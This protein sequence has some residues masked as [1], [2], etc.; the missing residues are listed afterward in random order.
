MNLAKAKAKVVKLF[1]SNL[2]KDTLWM[3]FAKLFNIVMQAG[4]FIIVARVLGA[5]NYGSFVGVTALAS[6]VFPF[7]ALG[8]EHILVQ[9][10]STNKASFSNYWGNCLLLLVAN[11][12]A[13]T[14]ILLLLSPLI[15]A[16][17]ISLLTILIILLADLIF[18]G[19]LDVSYKALTAVNMLNKVAH[20]AIFSTCGKLLAA[21]CLW[22]FFTNPSTNTW[23]C[24]Y[25]I[26]SIVM[27]IFSVM[28]VNKLAGYP[29]PLF[30]KLK[31][32]LKEGFYF[33]ISAS[34]YNVNSSLDKTMLASLSTLTATGIYGSAYRFI[35]V[36]YVPLFALFSATYTRF[37]Q[38]G[39]SG[40]KNS[41][42]FAKRLFPIILL[43][44][45]VSVV[46]Y[47]VFAPLL[48]A[49]LGEEYRSAVAALL[50]LAPLP[51]IASFQFL[52]ADTLT[53][54][55]H[56]KARSFVQV[57]AA[58]INVLLNIWLIPIY[59]W[60]G[61]AWATLI[62]DSLRLFSLWVIILFLYR[63]TAIAKH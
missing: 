12:I 8:S 34:A 35:D 45:V 32:N 62:S 41:L 14:I 4:Y 61:A 19:L 15:F 54:A 1:H 22:A 56:Q 20:L 42:G 39:A 5:E 27:G 43:Y 2:A 23:A 25:L 11:G 51:A 17:N 7:L 47:F 29:H 10:V 13:V 49:I 6:I 18:L 40:I 59:S 60:K 50:W 28:M 48:P 53:G 31:S 55:G 16:K 26:S 58:V 3:L 37:F 46:G 36:G 9:Q 44:A 38:H 30:S 63:R 24:L 52:A 33:S 21:L 57:A